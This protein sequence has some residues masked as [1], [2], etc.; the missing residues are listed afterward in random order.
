MPWYSSHGSDFNY[1]FQA[2]VDKTAP[3]LE[4]NYRSQPDILEDVRLAPV[5]VLQL[6][7]RLVHGGLE[8]VVEVAAVRGVPG[9]RPALAGLVLLQ[10]GHRRPRHQGKDRITRAQVRERPGGQLIDGGGA[11]RTRCVPARVKHDM[12]NDYLPPVPAHP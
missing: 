3:Q 12:L 4:Y 8:V 7:R 2:T 11:A 9:H 10:L 5:V 6:R 1:D